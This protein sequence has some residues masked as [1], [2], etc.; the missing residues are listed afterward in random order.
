MQH[1]HTEEREGSRKGGWREGQGPNVLDAETDARRSWLAGS[2]RTRTSRGLTASPGGRCDAMLRSRTLMPTMSTR[3]CHGASVTT[4][5]LTLGRADARAHRN[6]PGI[7]GRKKRKK[8]PPIRKSVGLGLPCC[9]S[10]PDFPFLSH[11]A[12]CSLE[13]AGRGSLTAPWCRY[14]SLLRAARQVD[15]PPS[16]KMSVT[17]AT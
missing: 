14:S 5:P 2:V 8:S 10:T 11:Y 15:S 9:S 3:G 6:V 1:V 4:C 17:L 16:P 13:Y 7:P 12:G